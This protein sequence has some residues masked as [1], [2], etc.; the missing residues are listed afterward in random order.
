[1]KVK[2]SFH[3]GTGQVAKNSWSTHVFRKRPRVCRG[4]PIK[5]PIQGFT[6]RVLEYEDRHEMVGLSGPQCL[7]FC[8]RGSDTK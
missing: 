3:Q 6:A 4:Y 8:R 2:L 7:A 1:V 5:D